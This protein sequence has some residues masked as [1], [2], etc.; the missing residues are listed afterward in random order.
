MLGGD[1]SNC[2]LK[3]IYKYIQC[4][5]CMTMTMSNSQGWGSLSQIN[6]QYLT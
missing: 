1:N 2:C 4:M 3:L 5:A 6:W